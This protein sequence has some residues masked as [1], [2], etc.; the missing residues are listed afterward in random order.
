MVGIPKKNPESTEKLGITLPV[1]LLRR[2]Y[3]IRGDK[4]RGTYTRGA[5]E[6]YFK[7]QDSRSDIQFFVAFDVHPFCSLYYKLHQEYNLSPTYEDILLLVLRHH[8]L[9]F[10][11]LRCKSDLISTLF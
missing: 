1:S 9:T 7:V 10:F 2:I 11:L 6:K 3:N 4:P 8:K 5:V